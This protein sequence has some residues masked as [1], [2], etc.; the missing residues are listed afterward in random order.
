[1]SDMEIYRIL[2]LAV[3][4]RRNELGLTQADV[5]GRI[6]LTRASLANIETG[7]Q[8]VLLHQLYRLANALEIKSITDLVPRSFQFAENSEPVQFEGSDVNDR[9][10]AQLEHF[11]RT[12]GSRN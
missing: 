6:D 1:M 11:V 5:A 12:L 7:R 9:E 10:R 8:K 3:A 2:G 4:K